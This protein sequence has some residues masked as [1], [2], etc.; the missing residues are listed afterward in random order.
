VKRGVAKPQK[1]LPLVAFLRQRPQRFPPLRAFRL[2]P[3]AGETWH[4]RHVSPINC[5]DFQVV[6]GVIALILRVLAKIYFIIML[7]LQVFFTLG[8]T[9][10]Y[11]HITSLGFT[12]HFKSFHKMLYTSKLAA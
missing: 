1:E 8:L 6:D 3:H 9:F 2:P 4:T 12:F 7:P 5:H 11:N 10:C